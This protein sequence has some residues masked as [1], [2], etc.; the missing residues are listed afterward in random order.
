MAGGAP[1]DEALAGS[2]AEPARFG[3]VFECRGREIWRYLAARLGGA[4]ADDLLGEV[5]VRAFAARATFDPRRGTARGWLYGI[6]HNVSRERL[7]TDAVA[8]RTAEV[9][10]RSA[11]AV[12]DPAD[13]VVDRGALQRVLAALS[14][15]RRDVVLLVGAM[16]LSY[17]EAAVALT[18]PVGTVRSRYFRGRRQLR[19]LLTSEGT[20][21]DAKRHT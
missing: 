21:N 17:E 19:R 16:G 2:V 14:D 10:S 13:E 5:F 7:R 18:I 6:A 12:A 20:L 3:M 9:G 8:R 4:A 1:D 11:G 15:D